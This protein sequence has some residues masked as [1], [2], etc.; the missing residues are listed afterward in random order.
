MFRPHLSLDCRKLWNIV[1]CWQIQWWTTDIIVKYSGYLA[2][3]PYIKLCE[4]C[5]NG[6][7]YTWPIEFSVHW[8]HVTCYV[9]IWCLVWFSIG[10]CQALQLIHWSRDALWL[11]VWYCH[12]IQLLYA[13]AIQCIIHLFH[14]LYT[15]WR[16]SAI[17]Q[18]STLK[19]RGHP[20]GESS[21]RHKS[22]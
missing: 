9:I 6:M 3:K 14:R 12:I 10:L 2:W 15:A 16:P 19:P 4:I 20:S 11:M 8:S 1:G 22:L 7:K 13:Q 17:I 5:L 21:M 18:S